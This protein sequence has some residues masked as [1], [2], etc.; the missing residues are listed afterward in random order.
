VLTV[1][2]TGELTHKASSTA[3]A[4]GKSRDKHATALKVKAGQWRVEVF[5]SAFC[6]K[7][8]WLFEHIF[9]HRHVCPVCQM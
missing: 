1:D 9:P 8:P 3:H 2:F 4:N 6:E 5:E 7:K